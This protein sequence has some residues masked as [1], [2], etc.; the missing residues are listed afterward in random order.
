MTRLAPLLWIAGMLCVVALVVQT[1]AHE[2]GAVLASAGWGIAAVAA[3]HLLPLVADALGWRALVTR[4]AR[5]SVRGAAWNRWL[6]ESVNGLLPVMQLG[7]ELVRIR[8]ATLAG[9]PVA[10]ATATMIADVTLGT[11]SQILFSILGV[12]LLLTRDATLTGPHILLGA[13]VIF[14]VPVVL[15]IT[16]QR[17][18]PAR[19]M[20]C[21]ATRLVARQGIFDRWGG[22]EAFDAALAAT[23]RARPTTIAL[24]W[25]SV[26]WLAG[27]GEIWLI[28]YVLGHPIS[29]LEATMYESLVQAV[30]SAAF[31]I[32]G[33]LGLQEGAF[34][35]LAM[36][37]GV[38]PELGLAAALVRRAREIGL[39]VP[40]LLAL[41]LMEGR[42][43]L[44]ED[45]S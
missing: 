33:G 4:N 41:T 12:A 27:T 16:V 45:R 32:P 28:F 37:V 26:G 40:G 8:V 3:F 14:A 5:P 22:P 17:A 24:W 30:R 10:M 6:G 11:L 23:Y 29:L 9:I 44:L 31:F 36:T 15:F 2:T 19:L 25:R 1:G 18:G 35:T 13:L 34:L 39:G 42:R 38:G 20:M 21:L 7:G 43:V